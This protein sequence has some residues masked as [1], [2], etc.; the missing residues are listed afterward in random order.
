[1]FAALLLEHLAPVLVDAD[2]GEPLLQ[3]LDA[4]EIDIGHG[5]ELER[6]V[7]AKAL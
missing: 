3:R 1:M 6:R 4:A 7:L 2:L 5:D